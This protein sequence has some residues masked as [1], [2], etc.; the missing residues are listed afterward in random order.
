MAVKLSFHERKWL[1][2][3]YWKVENV[4]DVQQH[5]R[6]EFDYNT[7]N[8]GN[9]NNKNLRKRKKLCRET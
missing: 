2:K 8:K 9:N 6:V 1:L 4:V 5:L 3:C 7:T